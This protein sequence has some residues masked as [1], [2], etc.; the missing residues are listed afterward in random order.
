MPQLLF[1]SGTGASLYAPYSLKLISNKFSIGGEGG[2][3]VG[4]SEGA[5][6]E[7]E[8]ENKKGGGGE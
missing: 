4:R 8:G 6:L 2:E 5:E 3:L 1:F 7:V